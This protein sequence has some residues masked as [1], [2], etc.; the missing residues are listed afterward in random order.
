[1]SWADVNEIMIARAQIQKRIRALKS[2]AEA[3]CSEKTDIPAPIFQNT[4]QAIQCNLDTIEASLMF[5]ADHMRPE[6]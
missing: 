3:M 2:A 5:I 6:L 4:H 1:M